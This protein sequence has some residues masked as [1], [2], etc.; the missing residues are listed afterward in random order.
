MDHEVDQD[1]DQLQNEKWL[2]K[3]LSI[4]LLVE[5]IMDIETNE[6]TWITT[7]EIVGIGCVFV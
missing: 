6:T 7:F 1:Q 3:W 2:S 4:S 5:H